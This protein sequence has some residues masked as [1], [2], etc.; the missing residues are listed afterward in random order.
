MTFTD[1]TVLIT[2]ADGFIG[3]HLTEALVQ[4]GTKV[5][6]RSYYNSFNNWGWLEDIDCLNE[7]EILT[8]VLSFQFIIC[9]KMSVFYL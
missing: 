6:A 4:E 7:I 2:C 8:E 1:K 5:K 9:F 3:S